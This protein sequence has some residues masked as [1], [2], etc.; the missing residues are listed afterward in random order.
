MNKKINVDGILHIDLRIFIFNSSE[1]VSL[2]IQQVACHLKTEFSCQLIPDAFMN[3]FIDE[4]LR[5][6]DKFEK[7]R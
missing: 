3:T 2:D 6:W 4:H 5:I 1:L 7:I